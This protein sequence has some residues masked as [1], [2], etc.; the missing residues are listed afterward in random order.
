MEAL[1]LSDREVVSFV[2][3]GG[4]TSL[5]FRLNREIPVSRRVIMTTTTK[6]YMPAADKYPTVL[7]SDKRPIKK[8]L[9]NILQSG[10]RPVLGQQLLPDNKVKGFSAERLDSLI[11]ENNGFA[12]FVLVEADGSKGRSLKGYLDYEPVVPRSTTVLVVVI[13]ADAIGRALDDSVVHRPET[14]SK[15]IGLK[16]GAIIE[17]ENIAGLIIHPLGVLRSCPPGARIVPF[18]NKTDCLKSRD[19]AYKLA[20]LLLGGRIKSVILGSAISKNPVIDIIDLR[21]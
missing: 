4:K 10:A 17:P 12:D 20:K 18:I 21:L 13:G 19:E 1:G 5:M 7:L 15:M 9:Q 11:Y 8:T 14:V 6:I 3:G 16:P 2:G